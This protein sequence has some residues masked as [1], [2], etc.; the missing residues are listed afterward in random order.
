MLEKIG[1]E[2]KKHRNNA[3]LTQEELAYEADI[4]RTYVSLVER[5]EKVPTLT[6]FFRICEALD[7]N[8][9]TFLERIE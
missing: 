1:E 4:H 6:T 3:D 8:P 2:V 9:S 5:N 7:T